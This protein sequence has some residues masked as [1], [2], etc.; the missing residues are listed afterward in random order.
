MNKIIFITGTSTGFGKLMTITLSKAGH[1]VIA[2]MRGTT[3]KNQAVAT[4]LPPWQ[5]WR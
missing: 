4:E 2:G 3:G 1:T 5:M